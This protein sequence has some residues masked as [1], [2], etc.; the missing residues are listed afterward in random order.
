MNHIFTDPQQER[1]LNYNGNNGISADDNHQAIRKETCRVSP[2]DGPDGKSARRAV[3]KLPQ[4]G[5]ME[6]RQEAAGSKR[7]LAQP[8]CPARSCSR[9]C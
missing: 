7:R 2:A 6:N 4:Q 8:G 3:E 9:T 1:L 5:I